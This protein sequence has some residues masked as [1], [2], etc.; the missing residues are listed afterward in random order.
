MSQS[1]SSHRYQHVFVLH[2][3]DHTDPRAK[4]SS[5]DLEAVLNGRFN[6]RIL[7]LN[8][9]SSHT[10]FSKYA[11][12][13]YENGESDQ[14]ALIDKE[15]RLWVHLCN[16]KAADVAAD[17]VLLMVCYFGHGFVRGSGFLKKNELWAGR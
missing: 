13:F 12:V 17:S 9:G 16:K 4:K 1:P 6:Y 3:Y 15:I 8:V 5:D 7:S 14:T 10:G 11:N 2:I